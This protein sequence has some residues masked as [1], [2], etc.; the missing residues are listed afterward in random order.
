M[1]D[2][3]LT[4]DA[5]LEVLRKMLPPIRVI[6][7]GT[8]SAIIFP[9]L[10]V[11]QAGFAVGTMLEIANLTADSVTLRRVPRDVKKVEVVEVKRKD[12]A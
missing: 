2:A 10:L 3:L 11:K 9:K 4:T 1:A 6:K 7:L 8:S 12:R 5:E